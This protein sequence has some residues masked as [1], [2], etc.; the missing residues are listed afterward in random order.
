MVAQDEDAFRA[1]LVRLMPALRGYGRALGGSIQAADELVQETLVRALA[2]DR[3]PGQPGELRAWLFTILRNAWL[4]S[5]RA[6]RR[7]EALEEGM[8]AAEAGTGAQDHIELDD[9]AR[10]IRGL[11]ADQ[12]EAVVLMG[13][14]GLPA[15]EAARICG[16]AEGTM[17]ARLSRARHA[18]RRTLQPRLRSGPPH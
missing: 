11:P 14:Q 15:A 1:A 17:R 3:R 2:N 4:T 12:R 7:T 9:L 13:A 16:V 5:L 18:L 10:A 6:G 8:E